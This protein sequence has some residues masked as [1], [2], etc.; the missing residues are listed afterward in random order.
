MPAPPYAG[1][2]PDTILDAVDA[3]GLRSDGRIL[4]L[5]SYENRVYRVGLEDAA[6]VVAKFYRPGRWSD[7]AIEEE[8]AFADALRAAELSVVAPLR[9]GGRSLHRHA[10]YRFA[11]FPLLGGHAPEIGAQAT[12]TAIGRTL[13][14]LH[15]IGAEHRFLHRT[16]MDPAARAE[17]AA[18]TLLDAGWI[19]AHHEDRF[20]DLCDDLLDAIDVATRRA[21]T[22]A[23]LCLHGDCHPGNVLWRDGVAH[24]VDLDDALAGP[25]VQDL[26]M[27]LSGPREEQ[28]TQL[29]WLLEGYEVFRAFDPAEL[30]LVAVLRAERLLH[31]H[32]WIARRWDDPAFPLAFAGIDAPPRR[33]DFLRQLAELVTATGEAPLRLP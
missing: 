13:G 19:P 9:F 27:L 25:A 8:H 30:H 5:N 20:T 31:H 32:A 21:G 24:F 28:R 2:D 7:A 12:M 17:Q 22:L 1:L 3:L 29:G 33:E 10:G 23:T 16:R 14:R 18:H 4:A 15:A 26:W 6:P 11:L